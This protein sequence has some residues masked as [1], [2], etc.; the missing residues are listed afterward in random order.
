MKADDAGAEETKTRIRK[1]ARKLMSER[2]ID[3]VKT[4]EIANDAGVNIAAINY[5]FRAKDLLARE[6]LTDVARRSA[7]YR[8]ALLEDCLK[9]VAA[10]GRAPDVSEIVRIFVDGYFRDDGLEEGRLLASLVLR[11]RFAEGGQRFDFVSAELDHMARRFIEA[12][13]LA[14]PHLSKAEVGWRYHFM[15]GTIVITMSDTNRGDR[16][17][18]LTDGLE[19]YRDE[20]TYRQEL[21][22]HLVRGFA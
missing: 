2:G 13:C 14:C 21:E 15:V 11:H 1:S 3:Q 16:M 18:A 5:H 6:V 9:T 4:R 22:R 19:D 8:L 10:E 17:V 20:A 7:T 12:F